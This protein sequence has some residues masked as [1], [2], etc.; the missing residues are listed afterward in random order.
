MPYALQKPLV[1]LDTIGV[2]RLS[3]IGDIIL[4]S[5]VVEALAKASPFSRISFFTASWVNELFAFSNNVEVIACRKPEKIRDYWQFHQQ[6]KARHFDILLA[7]QA[8]LRSNLLLPLINSKTRLGFDEIRGREGH[9][10][11]TDRHIGYQDNHLLDGFLQFLSPLDIAEP[12]QLYWP[13]RTDARIEEWVEHQVP[14]I[15]DWIAINLCASKA[16]RD[17]PLARFAQ[18]I[19]E[20]LNQNS[21]R[22]IV[23]IGSNT[24][25]EQQAA[26]QIL[27][28]LHQKNLSHKI[29]NQVG[30][31]TLPQLAALL[32]R[33]HC[34]IS[35]DS[36][37]VHLARAVNLPVIGLYAVARSALTGPYH[38]LDYCIDVYEQA[39][40]QYSKTYKSKPHKAPWHYRVHDAR[41]MQL[42]TVDAVN[43]KL[44][45]LMSETQ[46]KSSH[47]F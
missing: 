9:Q 44:E 46:P 16:E 35:P 18:L 11:L 25:V 43:N 22:R 23:L 40:A 27:Q 1:R 21:Q 33:C 38:A 30:R 20:I 10:W 8:S 2:L 37:P 15:H 28:A 12:D 6:H 34:L 7:M 32:L 42:I 26:Q 3:A 4:V 41:A 24:S 13:I 17:W 36:G 39:V 5:S 19:T 14:P 29:L 47:A 31:T 45:L